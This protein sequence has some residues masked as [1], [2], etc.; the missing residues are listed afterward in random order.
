MSEHKA[1]AE[2]ALKT[3]IAALGDGQPLEGL[4][5]FQVRAAADYALEQVGLLQEVK[6]AR[7]PASPGEEM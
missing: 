4:R 5:R 3:V 6:R 1:E 7:R 2:Q